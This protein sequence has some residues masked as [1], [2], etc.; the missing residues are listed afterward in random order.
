MAD[1]WNSDPDRENVNRDDQIVNRSSEDRVRGIA[2]DETDDEFEDSEDL[3]ED[4]VDDEDG[5]RI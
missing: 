2:G 5:S 3:D 4:E 1:K